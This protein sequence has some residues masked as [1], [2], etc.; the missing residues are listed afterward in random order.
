MLGVVLAVLL[1]IAI[2][3]GVF[4]ALVLRGAAGVDTWVI[5]QVVLITNSYLHPD[6]AFDDATFVY[7]HTLHMKG[8]T[9]TAETG[10]TVVAAKEIE[11][12]LAETPKFG[13]PIRIEMI[14][15]DGGTLRLLRDPATGG[16]R[17]LSPFVRKQAVRSPESVP[18]NARLSKVL[19]IRRVQIR[20]G[21]IEFDDGSGR[22]PMLLDQIELAANVDRQETSDTGATMHALDISLDRSPIFDLDVRGAASLDSLEVEIDLLNFTTALGPESYS[23]LP[24]SLQ[25]F[26]RQHEAEGDTRVQLR[27]EFAV[28][29]LEDATIDASVEMDDFSF[30]T[31]DLRLTLDQATMEFHV[32]DGIA[33][34]A[35]AR[36][37]LLEGVLNIQS[38]TQLKEVGDPSELTWNLSNIH[39]E[40]L[41]RLKSET[42]N[43][44]LLK[45]VLTSEG[46]VAANLNDIP[47]TIEGKGTIDLRDARL[48]KIPLLKSLE[49]VFSQFSSMLFSNSQM[50]ATAH[51]AF[52]L[53]G[54]GVNIST[55]KLESDFAA[56]DAH[57]SISYQGDLDIR[58][59]GGPVKRIQNQLGRVGDFLG[60]FT[61]KII[62][63]RIRGTVNN[64]SVSVQPLGIGS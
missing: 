7:P 25:A 12:T 59:R 29:S 22:P 55:L 38:V 49:N 16:L 17:G 37:D 5:R 27:G 8:V 58:A 63:Y 41:L 35:P 43:Q 28:N 61:S 4:L 33:R 1:A 24:P 20:N 64:P 13:E 46:T 23:A 31:G 56:I 47:D 30:A 62:S 57:G 39:L 51:T 15:L 48:L 26:V 40:P 18:E 3:V 14:T 44:D 60:I 54:N 11:I 19:Q 2:G 42:P 53:D 36:F 21:A 6:I 10:E 9:L 52:E 45:G 50:T 32:G 34:L